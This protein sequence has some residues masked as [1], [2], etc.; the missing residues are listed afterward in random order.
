MAKNVMEQLR[1]AGKVRRGMLGVTVQSV[2]SDLASSLGL[3]DVRGALVNSVQPGGPAESAGLRRG[4]VIVGF[5]GSAVA[6]SN[7]LR[8]QVAST[9]PGT[10][11]TLTV[12]R[13]NC[14]QQVRAMLG[15]LP[16]DKTGASVDGGGGQSSTGRLGVGVEPL[17]PDVAARLN[18]PG[19]AQ[20]LVVT[21]VDP[22]GP[23]ADAGIQEGDVI[24]EAN[25]QR[26]RS[27]QDLQAA[28]ERAGGSPL[29]LLVNRRGN[30]I[31]L[32]VRPHQ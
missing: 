2:T 25:R 11:V 18:L 8:N 24:E 15:E 19:D 1:K 30:S 13:D 5:N 9:P 23:A 3:S 17:T 32:T 29:L 28:E 20:G 31:F 16:A 22:I 27:A 21:D 14:E 10:E 7:A 4:D 6:D 26:V 12:S